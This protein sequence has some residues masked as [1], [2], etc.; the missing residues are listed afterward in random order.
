MEKCWLVLDFQ[1]LIE[2]GYPT[3]VLLSCI[4]QTLANFAAEKNV[5]SREV[6]SMPEITLD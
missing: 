3:D 2:N 5:W 4:N 6:P 1:L